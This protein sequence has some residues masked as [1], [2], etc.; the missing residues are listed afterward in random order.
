MTNFNVS[1]IYLLNTSYCIN[2]DFL[3]Y[4]KEKGADFNILSKSG[5]NFFHLYI[6]LLFY[7]PI[8]SKNINY[9]VNFLIKELFKFG[10]FRAN[11]R[12]LLSPQRIFSLLELLLLLQTKDD[13]EI[14]PSFF[15]RKSKKSFF[16][17]NKKKLEKDSFLKLY[18]YLKCY[19]E[20]DIIFTSKYRQ[21]LV[22][23]NDEDTDFKMINQCSIFSIDED[24]VPQSVKRFYFSM[25]AINF[26]FPH[27]VIVRQ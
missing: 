21:T 11:I 25:H 18:T 2:T 8:L 3:L 16:L 5:L 26:P 27:H 13:F 10:G 4:L 24:R 20:D 1:Q 22:K 15:P 19:G 12:I 7:H 14:S 9:H 6:V 17:K 23:I